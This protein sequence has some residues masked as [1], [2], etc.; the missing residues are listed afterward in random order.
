MEEYIYTGRAG[1]KRINRA[2]IEKALTGVA[3]TLGMTNDE[4]FYFIATILER[5]ISSYYD[6]T[7]SELLV[8]IAALA[9]QL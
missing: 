4:K 8:I 6:L 9:L 2:G 5:P 3:R 7:N 1:K